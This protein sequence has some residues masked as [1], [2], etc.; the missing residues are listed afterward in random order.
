VWAVQDP[1]HVALSMRAFYLLLLCV[2][3]YTGVMLFFAPVY[4][5]VDHPGVTCGIAVEGEWPSFHEAFA[6]SLQTLTTIGYGIPNGGNFFNKACG[7]ILIVVYFEAIVFIL[8][9][10]TIIGI[11]FSR[12]SVANKRASQIIF[13]DKAAIRCVRNRFYF[14]FQVGEASFFDYHPIVEAHIRVYGVLHEEART[15]AS[16]AE[17]RDMAETSETEPTVERA[18]FQ[19]RVM[20]LTNPNDELGGMLFLATP[21]V[22][23]HRIDLWSPMFPAAA[24]KTTTDDLHDG[25]AYLPGPRLP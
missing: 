10:A 4:M 19:T 18:F 13:S 22:V 12:I 21:Q 3:A 15:H 17:T 16:A 8:L 11:V 9:N 2:S 20:R 24:R 25:S 14:M 5:L 6:F 23:S 7:S 1:F